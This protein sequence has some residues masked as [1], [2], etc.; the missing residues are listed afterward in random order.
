MVGMADR[1]HSVKVLDHGFVKLV[2]HMGTD[3]SIIEAARMSTDKGFERWDLGDFCRKCGLK[4]E[5]ESSDFKVT[6]SKCEHVWEAVTGDAKL[7]GFLYKNHHATPFEMCELV[8]EVQAPIL[9]FREWHRHRTQSYN[10][11]SA[12]YIQ[13][14]DLH[15][16]PENIRMQ[17]KTNKQ[18]GEGELDKD[19]QGLITEHWYQEQR[20]VYATYDELVAMGVEKGLARINTPV[21]RYSRMRAKANLR[22]WLAFLTL[23]IAPNALWEIQ[24]YAQAVAFFVERLWPRSYALWE[25][26]TRYA[27]NLSRTEI[28]VLHDLLSQ[29]PGRPTDEQG[30]IIK[31]LGAAHDAVAK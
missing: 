30:A 1:G 11:M 25:E 7:L 16:I 28:R 17:S 9:V 27:M 26:H 19:K 14:P 21:S 2:D 31:R 15:Y 29:M 20:D 13:M 12:R 4:P 22:N 24:Q 10:E 6:R 18:G 8:I 5:D 23:R 3:E